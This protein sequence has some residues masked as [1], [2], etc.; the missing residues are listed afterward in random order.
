[1]RM[2]ITTCMVLSQLWNAHQLGKQTYGFEIVNRT[3]LESGIVHPILKRL[4]REGWVSMEYENVDEVRAGRPRRHY[5]K[6]TEAGL[7]PAEE[8]SKRV[9]KIAKL[10]A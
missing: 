1:M 7:A 9:E 10:S 2:T 3:S 8:A 6:L 5:Y 4:L